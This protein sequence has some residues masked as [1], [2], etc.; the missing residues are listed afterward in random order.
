MSPNPP[1]GRTRIFLVHGTWAGPTKW[2]FW[3]RTDR[4]VDEGQ[5]FREELKTA[6]EKN[7]RNVEFE[8]VDW[9]GY[10]LHCSRLKAVTTLRE[11]INKKL[12]ENDSGF[13]VSHSH[14]GNIALLANSDPNISSR[15]SGIVCMATPFLVA[16]PIGGRALGMSISNLSYLG[17]V[18]LCLLPVVG[19]CWW[20]FGQVTI[21]TLLF[22]GM[23]ALV[24]CSVLRSHQWPKS[25][26]EASTTPAPTN[27]FVIRAPGD[28]ASGALGVS[29][30]FEW[31]AGFLWR[32]CAEPFTTLKGKIALAVALPL[33]TFC[34]LWATNSYFRES[35]RIKPWSLISLAIISVVVFFLSAAW[36]FLLAVQAIRMIVRGVHGWD[37][38]FRTLGLAVSAEP[39]PV[40]TFPVWI[41]APKESPMGILAHSRIYENDKVI[42]EIAKWISTE[43]EKQD[44]I[45]PSQITA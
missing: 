45:D 16:T 1:P 24:P 40:G 31:L 25:E 37:L 34:L 10:N 18:L 13:I 6:I 39:S 21:L 42:Q 12:A 29:N 8:V 35:V 41:H 44:D 4:W 30:C 19:A 2:F 14:G 15:L 38:P 9:S 5:S 11:A 43:I 33:T 36:L 28:E 22:G 17:L 27:L 7:G 32:W 26:V 23:L 20:F 3:K